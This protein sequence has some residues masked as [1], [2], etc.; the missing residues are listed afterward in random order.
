MSEKNYDPRMHSAEHILNQVMVRNFSCSRS[1]NA[2]IERRKSKCD[3]YLPKAL[4]QDDINNISKQVNEII[5]SRLNIT[6]TYVSIEEASRFVDLSK[7]PENVGQNIRIISVGNFDH[8]ACIGPHVN[9]TIEIGKF[10]I[11][12][13]DFS[14]GIARIRFKLENN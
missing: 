11:I 5:L 4:S 7:L 14:N 2:H 9:N 1:F 12:S 8:C 13:S 10:E 3:Y 6:E